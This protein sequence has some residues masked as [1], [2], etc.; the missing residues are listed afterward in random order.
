M[1]IRENE[2]YG[3]LHSTKREHSFHRARRFWPV[4]CGEID[5]DGL[6]EDREQ[7][8]AE[9]VNL[10]QAGV[11]WWPDR[12][13]EAEHIAPQQAARYKG[14]AWEEPIAVRQGPS[15]RQKP[16]DAQGL[17]MKQCDF[18]MWSVLLPIAA[19]FTHS[20]PFNQQRPLALG[21]YLFGRLGHM[22]DFAHDPGD[23][24]AVGPAVLDHLRRPAI[25]PVSQILDRLHVG[26]FAARDMHSCDLALCDCIS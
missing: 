18:R 19:T 11:P 1:L 13:F 2:I 9:A 16:A 10:Y 7:L 3:L 26:R 5:V 23:R 17:K 22:H 20:T 14:D 24:L 15:V 6:I 21:C 8:F 25:Q 12:A 4:K